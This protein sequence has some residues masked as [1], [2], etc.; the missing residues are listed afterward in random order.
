M[1]PELGDR[2]LFGTRPLTKELRDLGEGRG[3]RV[4]LEKLKET[5]GRAFGMPTDVKA[6][7]GPPALAEVLHPV[8]HRAATNSELH[9]RG[10]RAG[11]PSGPSKKWASGPVARGRDRL[12]TASRGGR[13]VPLRTRS[14]GARPTGS[15]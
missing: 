4:D 12:Q 13:S 1:R 15:A 5:A 2:D 8:R 14:R 3:A 9:E 11:A 10:L 7:A 6:N